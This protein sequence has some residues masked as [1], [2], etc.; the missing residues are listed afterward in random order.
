M[1]SLF[2]S[3]KDRRVLEDLS[4]GRGYLISVYSPSNNNLYSAYYVQCESENLGK[5]DEIVKN[6]F[7]TDPIPIPLVTENTP[8]LVIRYLE[9]FPAIIFKNRKTLVVVGEYTPVYNFT[10][11]EYIAK[12]I[13]NV[14]FH[15]LPVI[16]YL[17]TAKET[18]AQLI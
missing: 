12:L 2:I 4:T 18:A 5:L 11:N 14:R 15:K 7:V 10:V 6:N 13:I 1:N 17:V 3:D 9:Q 16:E 8:K